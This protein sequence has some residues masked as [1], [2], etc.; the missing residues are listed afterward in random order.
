MLSLPGL[1]GILAIGLLEGGIVAAPRPDALA[2]LERFRSP[3]WALLLPAA[4]LIGTFSVLAAPGLALALV[5][6]AFAATPV[7][8]V[9][10]AVGVLRYT[11]VRVVA[12]TLVVGIGAALGSGWIGQVSDT[13]LTALG[14]L[15]LGAALVRLVP[16]VWL[17][18][19][20]LSMCLVDVVLLAVGVG[21]PAGAVM[22]GAASHIHAP[23][24]N[25][26]RIGPITTDYPDLIL[27]AILGS[28]LGGGQ[29]QRRA[30][31]L[32]AVLVAAFG[33]LL[34]VL[35][36]LPATVP[37]ALAFVL[38]SGH[39]RRPRWLRP[40]RCPRVAP[41]PQEAPV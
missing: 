12:V 4:I 18:W 28:S 38:I 13:V 25:Q 27:A 36:A 31:V 23:A 21:Q 24:L 30:A 8:A 37:L 1:I 14:C 11:G 15:A 10:A 34:P 35:G 26:A 32:V 17:P 3:A 33:L 6:V 16:R 29:L 19:G 7:L 20:V 9:L 40:A 5:L 39:A 2:W 41:L 22:S